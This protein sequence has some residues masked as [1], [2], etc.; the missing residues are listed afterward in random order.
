MKFE[1]LAEQERGH[2]F[3]ETK[4]KF[5]PIA[6]M[7]RRGGASLCAY[8]GF[9]LWHPLSKIDY[10]YIPLDCHGGLTFAKN[11]DGWFPK[12]MRWIGW[13]Y[14]HLGD[15]PFYDIGRTF[16]HSMPEKKWLVPAVKKEL[17]TAMQDFRWLFL[18]GWISVVFK[19][20][21]RWWAR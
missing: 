21:V 4:D 18:F 5:L 7:I 10:D 12:G 15:M 20:Q 3:Y 6:G 11:G 17:E 16:T 14:A 13:D 2:I 19:K 1:E 9:P 8:I